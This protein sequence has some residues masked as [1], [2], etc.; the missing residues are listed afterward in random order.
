MATKAI[1]DESFESD[2]INY[3]HAG[4]FEVKRGDYL[5]IQGFWH[6]TKDYGHW[7]IF[8]VNGPNDKPKGF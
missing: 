8:R 4:T 7:S 3:H 2:Y 1:T 5:Q 6:G